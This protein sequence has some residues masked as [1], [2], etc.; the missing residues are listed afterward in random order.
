MFITVKNRYFFTCF[1][2]LLFTSIC[3]SQGS[4][5]RVVINTN[6]FGSGDT[7]KLEAKYTVGERKLPP[8]TL[9]VIIKNVSWFFFCRVKRKKNACLPQTGIENRFQ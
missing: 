2:A 9:D 1:I 4:D 3:F 7:L 8:A 5:F 6:V